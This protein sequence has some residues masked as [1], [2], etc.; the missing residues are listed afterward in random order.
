MTVINTV[1]ETKTVIGAEAA[2]LITTKVVV[3]VNMMRTDAAEVGLME[4][5]TFLINIL[6]LISLFP[7]GELFL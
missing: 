1:E 4:G 2:A 3:E 5:R 7:H 6:L